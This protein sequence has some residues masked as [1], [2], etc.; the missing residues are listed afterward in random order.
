[1][2]AWLIRASQHP[3]RFQTHPEAAGWRGHA[4]F[5]PNTPSH[6]SRVSEWIIHCDFCLCLLVCS[7]VVPTSGLI[8][9]S[10]N[11]EQPLVSRL[12]TW[13][14]FAA[15]RLA[16]KAK[17]AGFY[18]QLNTDGSPGYSWW[19][20]FIIRW[21]H[22]FQLLMRAVNQVI[23]LRWRCFMYRVRQ[24][25]GQPEDD[26]LS[27]GGLNKHCAGLCCEQKLFVTSL[28]SNCASRSKMITYDLFLLVIRWVIEA[29]YTMTSLINN[30]FIVRK[31]RCRDTF[32][33][34]NKTQ[35]LSGGQ[36]VGI[37]NPTVWSCRYFRVIT[38]TFPINPHPSSTFGRR[39]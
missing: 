36:M 24:T 8:H 26:C 7:S 10:L 34:S 28:K 19:M 29:H 9:H 37:M 21:C 6:R 12:G 25:E 32:C 38:W 15:S 3:N 2:T 39:E 11:Y 20:S 4:S 23:S 33:S 1:M 22:C 5:T 14:I 18:A 16:Y 13:K 31:K 30:S 35:N 27:A 17:H